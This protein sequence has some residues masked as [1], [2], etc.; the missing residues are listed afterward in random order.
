M[1]TGVKVEYR[2][3]DIQ[4]VTLVAQSRSASIVTPKA[5]LKP[6]Q[7]VIFPQTETAMPG[8]YGGFDFGVE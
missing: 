4:P 6:G 3:E 1:Y 5:S 2:P 7:Y 8:G